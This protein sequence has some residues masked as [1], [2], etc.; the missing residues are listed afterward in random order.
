MKKIIEISSKDHDN[1]YCNFMPIAFKNLPKFSANKEFSYE[2]KDFI[3]LLIDNNLI[4]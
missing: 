4:L 1:K 3:K 2:M